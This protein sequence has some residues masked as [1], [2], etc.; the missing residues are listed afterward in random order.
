QQLYRKDVGGTN[1]EEQLTSSPGDKVPSSWSPDGRYLLYNHQSPNTGW[2]LWLLPIAGDHKPIALLQGP[3]NER[4]AVLSP[5]QKWLLYQSDESGRGEVYVQAFT[6]TSLLPVKVQI[7]NQ[8]GTRPYWRPDGN[9]ILYEAPTENGRIALMAAAI[10]VRNGGIQAEAPRELFNVPAVSV[11]VASW[12]SA[13]GV[14][15]ESAVNDDG[16]LL[17]VQEPASPVS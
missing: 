9:E 17:L 12:A 15:R 3:F 11:N 4:Q 5:D 7:S 2:D 10:R 14:T 13:S 1:A 8:G 6:G 16:Q